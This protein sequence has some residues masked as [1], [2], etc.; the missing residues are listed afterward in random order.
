[1]ASEKASAVHHH[2]QNSEVEVPVEEKEVQ[3][4]PIEYIEGRR[5]SDIAT[6]ES[7]LKEYQT[8]SFARALDFIGQ[9]RAQNTAADFLKERILAAQEKHGDH[10]SADEGWHGCLTLS[11]KEF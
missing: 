11:A 1:M 7:A 8:G 9:I 3:Y 5:I 2:N 4:G 10:A 6:Y